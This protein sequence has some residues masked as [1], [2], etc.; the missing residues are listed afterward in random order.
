MRNLSI[1]C[2]LALALALSAPA[3]AEVQNVKVSG[4]I[5]IRGIFQ[6]DLDLYDVNTG[7][8][9]NEE[10][11]LSF[12]RLRVD[13][14][15][16]DN[17]SAM[18]RILNQ[19]QWDTETASDTALLIDSAYITLKELL[20]SPLTVTI[21]R[22]DVVYGD[23]FIVGAG[24]LQDI[25]G[26][27]AG[28][29]QYS[30][31]NGYD[32]I[33]AVLDYDPV[34][35]SLIYAKINETDLNGTAGS[36]DRSLYGAELSYDFDS[37]DANLTGYL[38]VDDDGT[39]AYTIVDPVGLATATYEDS[40]TYCLGLRGDVTPIDN[41]D[42]QGE[43]AFQMGEITDTLGGGAGVVSPNANRD[44]EAW[45]LDVAGEYSW[46]DVTYTPS[47]LLEYVYR[48]GEERA[49]AGDYEAWN[50]MFTGK[51]YGLIYDFLAGRNSPGAGTTATTGTNGIYTTTDANDTQ[52]TSNNHLIKIA[53]TIEP[54][55]DL[56]VSLAWL[57]IWFDEEPIAGRDDEV[58][59]EV[60]IIA[61]YDYTED[62]QFALAA[63][64][65]LPGDYY[66]AGSDDNATSVMGSVSVE[67]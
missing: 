19:R 57:G 43:I 11:F 67:F 47:L 50:S 35:V 24:R 25:E 53:G 49:E 8:T 17:V 41:L 23:G 66:V 18:V 29:N 1:L 56:S 9:G 61:V 12:V 33:T 44:R 30:M 59:Q 36:Y 10:G 7:T 27:L 5:T 28:Y 3:F 31:D 6:E 15:L 40:I 13:A 4:D 55:D 21:G 39:F 62:V 2:I 63:G 60:D 52:P 14:D 20:Y 42:L 45:A 38:M 48:S 32:A 26:A 54:I 22:Q 16:T 46:A 37:Y 34:T 51:F 58:G 64:W 65:F